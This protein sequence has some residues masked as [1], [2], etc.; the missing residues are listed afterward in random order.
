M[1]WPGERMRHG[2]SARGIKT[3]LPRTVNIQVEDATFVRTIVNEYKTR[4]RQGEWVVPIFIDKDDHQRIV[5]GN[6]RA[7]AY[8]ELGM[9]IPAI[10]VD[11]IRTL[12][13]LVN[14]SSDQVY[15]ILMGRNQK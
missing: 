7:Q 5:D 15:Y 4:I 8:K 12:Q 6:H 1:S 3:V 2:C 11:R 13:L 10:Y 14:N 9:E